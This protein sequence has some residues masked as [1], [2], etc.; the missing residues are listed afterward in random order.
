M[1]TQCEIEGESEGTVKV[2]EKVRSNELQINK[3]VMEL[4]RKVTKKIA[5]IIL[6]F[7]IL[8]VSISAQGQTTQPE[9]SDEQVSP[10]AVEL[11]LSSASLP[12]R[13]K[14]NVAFQNWEESTF[15]LNAPIFY[16]LKNLQKSINKKFGDVLYVDDSF[17]NNGNDG[18]EAY[19]YKSKP[20][21][22]FIR[23]GRLVNRIP[24]RLKVRFRGEYPFVLSFLFF[25]K[26]IIIAQPQEFVF[27]VRVDYLTRMEISPDLNAIAKTDF[28]VDWITYP[29][30]VLGGFVKFRVTEQVEKSLNSILQKKAKK[31]D[32]TIEKFFKIPQ[33]LSSLNKS[34]ETP[35]KIEK[36]LGLW[37]KVDMSPRISSSPLFYSLRDRLGFIFGM[38]GKIKFVVEDKDLDTPPPILSNSKRP[39]FS[40]SLKKNI[41]ENFTIRSSVAISVDSMQKF[42]SDELVKGRFFVGEGDREMRMEEIYLSLVEDKNGEKKLLTDIYLR[43]FGDANVS[44][45]I[46]MKITFLPKVDRQQKTIRMEAVDLE[47]ISESRLL[48]FFVDSNK[49]D[50]AERLS[51]EVFLSITEYLSKIEDVFNQNLYE[52]QPQEKII[53]RANINETTIEDIALKDDYIFVGF[54]AKGKASFELTNLF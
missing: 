38:S 21:S 6:I 54:E 37:S 49:D 22:V 50:F 43:R 11:E 41:K 16:P 27:D 7:L 45:Q 47:T 28:E 17:E 10:G 1:A 35:Q 48:N 52:L 51:N 42:I 29:Y 44:N 31:F 5:Y 2:R 24:M 23:K 36:E 25:K 33:S 26:K 46:R 4:Y 8:Q 20:I 19:V 12:F 15:F 3:T 40:P 30:V 14:E 13:E 53:V 39:F 18:I 9:T 34:L 32:T